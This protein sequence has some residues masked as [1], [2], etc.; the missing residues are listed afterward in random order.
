[1]FG[2]QKR[3]AQSIVSVACESAENVVQ[4]PEL[5]PS[6]AERSSGFQRNFV[7]FLAAREAVVD[8]FSPGPL[9]V[10]VDFVM[11]ML[12]PFPCELPRLLVRPSAVER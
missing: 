12:V 4:G 9:L 8:L 2:M 1:M 6:E 3:A 5:A 10:E 7:A 11:A